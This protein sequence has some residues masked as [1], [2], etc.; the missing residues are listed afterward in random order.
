MVFRT[1]SHFRL[2]IHFLVVYFFTSGLETPTGIYIVTEP[3]V[4]LR[5]YLDSME[6]AVFIILIPSFIRL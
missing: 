3:I 2:H 5:T 4:P 1:F 6:G